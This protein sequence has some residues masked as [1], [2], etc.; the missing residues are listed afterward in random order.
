MK[1][2]FVK[3]L[4]FLM[5]LTMIVGTLGTVVV[6]AADC[7]HEPAGE[8]V[9][10]VKATCDTAGYTRYLCKLCGE[11]YVDPASVEL[12]TGEHNWV[13]AP[14]IPATCDKPGYVAHKVC[15]AC[16]KTKDKVEDPN[17]PALGHEWII[18]YKV[19][20]T[21]TDPGYTTKKCAR[22]LAEDK[23][24]FHCTCEP[25]TETGSVA[26]CDCVPSD[27]NGWKV[28]IPAKGHKFI[29]K[30]TEVPQHCE[31]GKVTITCEGCDYNNEIVNEAN[32]T[33]KNMNLSVVAEGATATA[34][35]Q[36]VIDALKAIGKE[37]GNTCGDDY[38]EG[39]ICIVCKLTQK[40]KPSV[41]AC[42]NSVDIKTED[43]EYKVDV[44]NYKAEMATV[45]G[46]TFAIGSVTKVDATHYAA[47]WKLVYCNDCKTYDVVALEKG[48]HSFNDGTWTDAEGNTYSTTETA[49]NYY[50]DKKY[51][52]IEM[53]LVQSCACGATKNAGTKAATG[54]DFDWKDGNTQMGTVPVA[55]TCTANG[56]THY[57]CEFCDYEYDELGQLALGHDYG[58]WK[59]AASYTCGATPA[60]G[61][62]ERV[63][64]RKYNGVACALVG[65]KET[66]EAPANKTHAYAASVATAATCVANAVYEWKCSD[67]GNVGTKP[68]DVT[69]PVSGFN[70]NNH[71]VKAT[72]TGKVVETGVVAQTCT[73]K[74]KDRY[75]C[76]CGKTLDLEVGEKAAHTYID[77]YHADGCT[78]TW[79]TNEEDGSIK[80]TK[81]GCVA[82]CKEYRKHAAT[83]QAGGVTKA[84]KFCSVCGVDK[85]DEKPTIVGKDAN[86]HFADA[87]ENGAQTVAATCIE[88]E[89]T[90]K[91]YSCCGGVKK[92]YT[93]TAVNAN[94]HK[95]VTF[96]AK[97]PA[98][99]TTKGTEAYY[100][101][102]DC[103][104]LVKATKIGSGETEDDYQ[105]AQVTPGTTDT[106]VITAPTEINKLSTNGQHNFTVA[107]DESNKFAAKAETCTDKGNIEYIVCQNANCTYIKVEGKDPFV[108]T[109]GNPDDA[110]NLPDE[111]WDEVEIPA[112]GDAH[113]V[114]YSAYYTN[115]LKATGT[116]PTC[117]EGAWIKPAD[118]TV[119]DDYV[120][121]KCVIDKKPDTYWAPALGHA[122]TGADGALEAGLD[123]VKVNDVNGTNYNCTMP[124]YTVESCA[125][126]DYEHFIGYTVA[127]QTAHTWTDANNDGVR[128]ANATIPAGCLTAGKL[129]YRCQNANCDYKEE[130]TGAPAKGHYVVLTSGEK[131]I[132]FSCKNDAWKEFEGL[133]CAGGCG[134]TVNKAKVDEIGHKVVNSQVAAT[135]LTDGHYISYCADCGETYSAVTVTN[136]Q[137]DYKH[138]VNSIL[139]STTDGV[140]TWYCP[141]CKQ[142]YEVAVV[143]Q[144]VVTGTA[145]AKTVTASNNVTFT[146]NVAGVAKEFKTMKIEVTFDA[147]KYDFVGATSALTNNVF[148]SVNGNVVGITLVS[149]TNV[150][151]S[152]EGTDLVVLEFAAKKYAVGETTFAVSKIDDAAYAASAKV[153]VTGLGNATGSGYITA[154]DALAI[155]D[156]EEFNATFDIN[157]D[158]MVDLI[159]VS[160]VG[161]FAASQQT[162]KDYLVMLG[163][164]DE[165]QATIDALYAD[166]LLADCTNDGLVNIN[167]YYK[168]SSSVEIVLNS[169]ADYQD[170]DFASVEDLVMSVMLKLVN[171]QPL[172]PAP[173][174]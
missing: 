150:T 72:D 75:L 146:V 122:K 125:R 60:D 21:C 15:S 62:M 18:D 89:Y 121:S 2:T 52:A 118:V 50:K 162:A 36:S 35:Q 159:D 119:A 19:D 155:L 114:R 104:K 148:T 154:E 108:P 25:E 97:V 123:Q 174:A 1:N 149:S 59:Y 158:G 5:A 13:D 130:E 69:F 41:G 22:C 45:D 20:A 71:A 156:T 78:S 81:Y 117:T 115:V 142:T 82:G 80:F 151:T 32:H 116:V 57:D 74:Q 134:W 105:V 157:G 137:G 109:D 133:T 166:G 140:Q 10:V 170:I 164:Y 101:C 96:V 67:C 165:I 145:S 102:N 126:C 56:Y 38:K 139:R 43:G 138:S 93:S 44:N 160:L 163:T 100:K 147:G 127:T 54:H 110:N 87:S 51:H 83:C 131:A 107:A 152:A 37:F 64:T 168:L 171:N 3:V 173:L 167:D 135:C 73:T 11:E 111:I 66:K 143:A 12:A 4:S 161:T 9:Q 79:E 29:Y 58:E 14:A 31:G 90:L 26:D 40:T 120:C 46:K 92:V 33:W 68:E 76:D 113:K 16:G 61:Q 7:T 65:Y 95:N 48:E 98:T 55:A 103:N 141:D 77:N 94:N 23:T 34:E 91:Y 129:V 86:N 8:P 85:S 124:S 49:T 153:N 106:N 28:I 136:P 144:A 70:A 63:C 6:F 84:G 112:H 27:E 128:E 24:L 169:Y 99:C 132:T 42:V 88:K 53:T 17:A 39:E 47:G 172:V 30:V